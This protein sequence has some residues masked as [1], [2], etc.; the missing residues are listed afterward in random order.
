[1]YYIGLGRELAY[2]TA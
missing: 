2:A 1:M